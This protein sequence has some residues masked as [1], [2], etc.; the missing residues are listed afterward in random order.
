MECTGG[1]NT[2]RCRSASTRPKE[3]MEMT[4]ADTI[5]QACAILPGNFKEDETE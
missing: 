3:L 5:E 2:H 1:R 4:G